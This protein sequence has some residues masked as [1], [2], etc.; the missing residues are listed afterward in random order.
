[1]NV[2]GVLVDGSWIDDPKVV[3]DEFYDHF[4]K[5]FCQPSPK[6]TFMDMDF[7]NVLTAEESH[8]IEGDVSNEEIKNAVWEC[9]TDKAPGPDGFS[10][11][12][13]ADIGTSLKATS[14]LLLGISF[15][16]VI[17]LLDAT[18]FLLRSFQ[19]IQTPM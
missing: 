2:R 6:N 4:S 8:R 16:T 17:F 11:G 14:F 18:L 7:P 12:F 19:N 13:F 3:K 15:L 10:F 1:M 9:G 5:R